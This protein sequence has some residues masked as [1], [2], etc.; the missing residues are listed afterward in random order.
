MTEVN[1][2]RFC[3]EKSTINSPVWEQIG[4]VKAA[5]T[6]NSTKYYSFEDKNESVGKFMYRIKSVDYD[7]SF[8][9]SEALSVDLIS[10]GS[11]TI[12]QNYPNPFNPETIIQYA[13]PLSSSVK[14]T[15][16]NS[17]GQ[18]VKVLVNGIQDAN[19]YQ[20]NFNGAGLSSGLYFY[21]LTA[22]SL[23]GSSNFSS[24]KSMILLK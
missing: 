16:I 20:V 13:V 22:H 15:V 12:S 14:I 7:G 18:T 21:T 17:L 24:S 3:I 11:F 4:F 10:P 9:Y 2:A 8:K 6:S 19:R 1:S 23:D 5:G